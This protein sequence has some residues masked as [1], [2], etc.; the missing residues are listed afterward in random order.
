MWLLD[1]PKNMLAYFVGAMDLWRQWNAEKAE[2]LPDD[3]AIDRQAAAL[4]RPA[5]TENARLRAL[6]LVSDRND[7]RGV[8]TKGMMIGVGTRT[9]GQRR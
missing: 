2:T 5:T 3:E 6:E 9:M 7:S 1:L 4:A 8:S